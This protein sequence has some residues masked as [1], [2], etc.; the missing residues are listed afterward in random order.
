MH[1]HIN[2][3]GG[4]LINILGGIFFSHVSGIEIL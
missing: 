1:A 3:A 2:K 4:Y